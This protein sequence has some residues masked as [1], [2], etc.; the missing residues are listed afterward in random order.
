VALLTPLV[1]YG[2]ASGQLSASVIWLGL[3]LLPIGLAFMILVELPDYEADHPTDKR[4]WVV[5]LGRDRAGNLHNSLLLLSYVLL[6][7]VAGTGRLPAPVAGLLWWTLPLAVWQVCG[8]WLRVHRG[9][10]HY[11]LLAGG[12]MALVGLYGLLAGLGYWL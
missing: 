12:G 2:V 8:V 11:G 1:G 7:L 4:N 3:P 6:A 9:W 5:R 10:R